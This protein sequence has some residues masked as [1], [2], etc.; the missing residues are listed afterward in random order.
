MTL[1]DIQ[2]MDADN[3]GNVDKAEF[4]SFM[5]VTMQRVDPEDIE[6]LLGLFKRLDSD[7]SGYLNAADLKAHAGERLRSPSVIRETQT[8]FSNP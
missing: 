6:S 7:G 3:D 2:E 5:L 1:A 4:L 8:P